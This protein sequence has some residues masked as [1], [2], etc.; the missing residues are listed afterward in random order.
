M[1]LKTVT[2][3]HAAGILHTDIRPNNICFC[4]ESKAVYLID[5]GNAKKH[6]DEK[7]VGE[8]LERL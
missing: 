6:P 8:E 3:I 7:C 1:L 5:F 4:L 2:A